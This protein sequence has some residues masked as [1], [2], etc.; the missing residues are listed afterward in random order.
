[1]RKW[2][3]FPV[4]LGTILLP[5]FIRPQSQ[6]HLSN[7]QVQLWPEYDQ[8]SMLVIYDFKVADGAS[9]PLDLPIR[10]PKVGNLVAV[11]SQVTGGGLVDADFTG[12]VIDGDWQSITIKLQS[13]ADYHVEYYQPIDKSGIVRQFSYVWPGDY[14]IDDL[15]VS[16][17]MPVD[18]TQI[19]AD[20]LL[21]QNQGSDGVTYFEK[22]FG[23]LPAGQQFTLEIHY[24]KTSDKLSVPQPNVQPSEPLSSAL[25]RVMFG[26]YVP[27]LLG[28]LGIILVAGV[29]VVFWR[30]N[31]GVRVGVRRRHSPQ[32][33][34]GGME[35][36]CHQCGTR[37]QKG[38]RFCRVCGTRLRQ[39]G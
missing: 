20:P 37:A 35:I 12:P 38:D 2:S 33:E 32:S 16:V 34:A 24:T 6:I 39:E 15:N 17:R 5:L 31:R 7:L 10:I 18:T 3:S 14:Q 29:L 22:D 28:I 4:I 13:A 1:M 36:Y 27:Y 23:S 25:G 19:S 9:F 8:P 11:A 26:N 30:S 21:T